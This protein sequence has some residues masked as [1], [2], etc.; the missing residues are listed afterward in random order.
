MEKVVQFSGDEF[1]QVGEI[2][3][4]FWERGSTG[5]PPKFVIFMGGVGAGKTTIRRQQFAEGFVHFDIG[6][7]YQ[8]LRKTFSSDNPK[9]ESYTS[10]AGD[11]IL[12][13]SINEKKNIVIEII[14]DSAEVITPVIDK[15]KEIGYDVSVNGITC[16]P[17]EAYARHHKAVKE[18]KDYLSAY[19]TQ[20]ATLGVFYSHFSL[21]E[22]P[23][24]PEGK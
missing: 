4:P 11:L 7:I 22:M 19:F 10:L 8:A 6:E 12:K 20:E 2:A 15:M 18:D 21:G 3:K 14:G 13:E 23:V 17:A 24:S 1:L 9:I 5:N 16:D